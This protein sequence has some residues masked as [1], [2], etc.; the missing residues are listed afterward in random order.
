MKIAVMVMACLVSAM[1]GFAAGRAA[2]DT[3]TRNYGQTADGLASTIEIPTATG[4]IRVPADHGVE[5]Q[6]DEDTTPT[7]KHSE[8]VD[9]QSSGLKTSSDQAAQSFKSDMPSVGGFGFTSTGGGA[10]F[11]FKSLAKSGSTWLWI[12]GGLAVIAGAVAGYLRKSVTL[13]LTVS[14]AGVALI[15]VGWF[16]D[17]QPVLAALIALLV[18]A[19]VTVYLLM[20]TKWGRDTWD[21]LVDVVRG[22]E[23]APVV[24]SDVGAQDRIDTSK[25]VKS[26][27][28]QTM[29]NA[30]RG[31]RIISEAKKEA[32]VTKKTV[33]PTLNAADV[34]PEQP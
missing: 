32:G 25:T 10:Q 30:D 26:S 8:S 21:T 19:G 5:I 24:A 34:N 14:G 33:K 27:I 7:R 29:R 23:D 13:G 20:Q 18:L 22:V 2:N 3:P 17:Q 31:K 15:V 12:I 1:L 6:L 4:V 11:T 9:A 28:G 16:L